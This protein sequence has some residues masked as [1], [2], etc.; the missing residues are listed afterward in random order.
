MEIQTKHL[1]H[2]QFKY[3][4]LRC[5][6]IGWPIL[7]FFFVGWFFFLYFFLSSQGEDASFGGCFMRKAFAKWL[8]ADS[9]CWI[10]LLLSLLKWYL[11][12]LCRQPACYR[13]GPESSFVTL[14]SY[15]SYLLN[16]VDSQHKLEKQYVLNLDQLIPQQIHS[17]LASFINQNIKQ[18]FSH[19]RK[20]SM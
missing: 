7:F 5:V 14:T 13:G 4:K 2:Y 19:P 18:L 11:P 9:C 10:L 17:L 3:W 20:T 15:L 16:H 1:P 12:K 6:V 8:L